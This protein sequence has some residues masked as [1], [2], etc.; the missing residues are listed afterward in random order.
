[1]TIDAADGEQ[2]I[3]WKSSTHSSS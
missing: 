2:S 3:T 1:M